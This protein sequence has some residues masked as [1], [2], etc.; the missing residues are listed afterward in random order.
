[1]C[2]VS[3]AGLSERIALKLRVLPKCTP[4]KPL[5]HRPGRAVHSAA[6]CLPFAPMRARTKTQHSQRCHLQRVQ[7]SCIP[8]TGRLR[9][10][11]RGG[12]RGAVAFLVLQPE[13]HRHTT[14]ATAQPARTHLA[15][16]RRCRLHASG[17]IAA[18]IKL[19]PP[20]RVSMK[21]LRCIVAL[22]NLPTLT[23]VATA[24]QASLPRSRALPYTRRQRPC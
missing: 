11:L 21:T 23:A 19:R 10:R 22:C 17:L 6:R 7:M 24:F 3:A 16:P 2:H 20:Q 12:K 14:S 9:L 15:W 4:V 1:M 13:A 5:R 8:V 18:A